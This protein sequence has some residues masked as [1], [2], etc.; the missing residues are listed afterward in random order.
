MRPTT[1]N[2]CQSKEKQLS[3]RNRMFKFLE[4]V[5]IFDLMI[6]PVTYI[7]S[8]FK[9]K[10]SMKQ[11]K[12]NPFKFTLKFPFELSFLEFLSIRYSDITNQICTFCFSHMIVELCAL[13]I[14]LT[15]Q[16]IE[17]ILNLNFFLLSKCFQALLNLVK[18]VLKMFVTE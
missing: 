11:R 5:E 14:S 8:R 4:I 16:V 2:S 18:V 13:F 15:F 7:R 12:I 6:Y 3:Y 1:D 10:N 9:K 17:E